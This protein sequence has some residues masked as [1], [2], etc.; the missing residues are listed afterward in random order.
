MSLQSQDPFYT[1]IKDTP[2][3]LTSLNLYKCQMDLYQRDLLT[4]S[5]QHHGQNQVAAVH[6]SSINEKTFFDDFMKYEAEAVDFYNLQIQSK[7]NSSPKRPKIQFNVV[8]LVLLLTPVATSNSLHPS[9]SLRNSTLVSLKP[10]N[11]LPKYR[12]KARS[13]ILKAIS[14]YGRVKVEASSVPSSDRE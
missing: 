13:S 4:Q 2:L 12:R 3:P 6:K 14:R 11:E 9:D 7:F 1:L 8:A 5:I 10:R